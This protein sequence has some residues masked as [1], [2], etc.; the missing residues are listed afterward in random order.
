MATR[1]VLLQAFYNQFF[2]LTQELRAMFPDDPDFV[3]FENALKLLQKTNP[4]L[5]L[6]YYK[7]NVL[8]TQFAAK[9]AARDES[10]F[11]NYT[12]DEYHEDVGGAD[13]IGKL[14]Q[15]WAVLSADSRKMVWE[16][17]TALDQLARHLSK[18]D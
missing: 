9:I 17:I 4:G 8:E 10:F 18:S 7:R 16:Y 12:Y 14:K 13:V 15:Y 1:G 2:A 5:G 3:L 11:V 6:V